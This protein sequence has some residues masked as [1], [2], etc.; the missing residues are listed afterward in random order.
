MIRFRP[1]TSH[2]ESGRTGRTIEMR[3]RM[4]NFDSLY[5]RIGTSFLDAVKRSV[6]LL[7]RT[8]RNSKNFRNFHF[9]E[10]VL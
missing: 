5:L 1:V 8:F 4:V 9:G 3:F 10:P 7:P 6:F 2:A